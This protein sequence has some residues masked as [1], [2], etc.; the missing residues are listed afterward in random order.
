MSSTH[1]IRIGEVA[2]AIGISVFGLT[3]W[4]R[5]NGHKGLRPT[6]VQ[7]GT[8]LEF[9]WGDVAVF[10][11]TKYLIDANMPLPM[12]FTFASAIVEA[13]WPHLFDVEKPHWELTP[14]NALVDFYLGPCEPLKGRKAWSVSAIEGESVAARTK[15]GLDEVSSQSFPARIVMTVW[16]G[17][18]ILDAFA[19]LTD[20]DHQPPRVRNNFKK[21]R[22]QFRQPAD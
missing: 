14:D 6:I 7:E 9:S 16:A 19:K 8:W 13:R 10:A 22:Q 17:H 4:I 21:A 20:M 1:K 2:A 3:H 11:L 5:R 18:I 15:R 12:A